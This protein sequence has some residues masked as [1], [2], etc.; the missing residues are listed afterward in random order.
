MMRNFF[1]KATFIF[2]CNLPIIS[3]V[4]YADTQISEKQINVVLRYDDYGTTSSTELEIKILN[5]LK[6]KGVSCTFGVIPYPRGL[7][8]A[9]TQKKADILNKALKEGTVEVAIHG[10]DHSPGRNGILGEFNGL[11]YD[12][13]MEKIV[14]GIDF[15]QQM[16]ESQISTFIPPFNQYD[17]NT[18]RILEHVNF[19]CISGNGLG[20]GKE[21]SSL[22]FLPMTCKIDEV[23]DAVKSARL[24]DDLQPIIVV[25][26]HDY[27]FI[28]VSKRLGTFSSQEFDE[29]LSWLT[30]QRDV[31]VTS[32]QQAIAV[33]KDLT[34]VR[35]STF[36]SFS[37][38]DILIP[39]SVKRLLN[40]PSGVYLSSQEATTAKRMLWILIFFIYCSISIVS[41]YIS[42]L[43][44]MILFPNSRFAS[45]TFR[46]GGAALL[47]LL[48][49]FELKDQHHGFI[50][51]FGI[52]MFAGAYIGT[53]IC[54]LK[55]KKMS[56]QK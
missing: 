36:R 3:T 49:Y 22:T 1:W 16:F 6:R 45:Y 48:L 41:A 13:Q 56:V 8:N 20:V 54:H 15:L 51:V 31:I 42:F 38:L 46:Y 50:A 32:I 52:A 35:Y 7:H 21:S 5:S 2:V 34:H 39:K 37:K 14:K 28:E 17:L 53:W 47:L 33:R 55:L 18:I 40:I 25:M 19:K 26:F 27:D 10:F 23:R 9:L 29:L 4:V 30:S 24:I 43:I 12:R 11:Q 44:G